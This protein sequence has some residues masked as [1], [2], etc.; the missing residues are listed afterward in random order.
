M[1]I[2]TKTN[3]W[4]NKIYFSHCEK[5]DFCIYLTLEQFFLDTISRLKVRNYYKMNNNATI[6]IKRLLTSTLVAI[7]IIYYIFLT[8]EAIFKI[9]QEEYIFM[10]NCFMFVFC[11][12]LL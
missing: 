2:N 3:I 6:G 8:P 4:I 11:I 10:V 7:S 5:S 9:V 12:Y 1:V